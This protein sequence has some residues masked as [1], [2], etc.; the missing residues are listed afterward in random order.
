[1]RELSGGQKSL[2]AIAFILSIQMCY[3]CMIYTFDE[4]DSALDP[5][6]NRRLSSL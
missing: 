4:I 1:M 5:E 2:V 6:N 3:G